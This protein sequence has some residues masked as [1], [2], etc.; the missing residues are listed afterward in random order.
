MNAK[1]I[2]SELKQLGVLAN[3]KTFKTF[4][5]FFKIEVTTKRFKNPINKN[6]SWG[7]FTENECKIIKKYLLS[8]NAN[9]MFEHIKGMSLDES[10]LN[11]FHNGYEFRVRR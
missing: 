10:E 5:G 6:D 3:V 4:G 1:Q 11:L 7:M 8:I 9:S 2:K